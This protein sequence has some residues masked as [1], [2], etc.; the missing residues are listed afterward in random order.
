MDSKPDFDPVAAGKA[1]GGGP[2]T[3]TQGG[4]A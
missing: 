3:P 4:H 1:A 2:Q